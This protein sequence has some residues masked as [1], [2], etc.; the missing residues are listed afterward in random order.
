ME[1]SSVSLTP[2]VVKER[3]IPYWKQIVAGGLF[4]GFSPV[5]SGTVASAVACGFY[6][7]PGLSNPL[8][9]LSMAAVAFFAGIPLVDDVEERLGEDPAFFTL[10]EFAGQ[11]FVLASPIFPS[12]FIGAHRVSDVPYLRHRKDL[13]RELARQQGWSDGRDGGRHC[14]RTLRVD[15]RPRNLVRA[16]AGWHRLRIPFRVRL[17]VAAR[18][19]PSP[20]RCSLPCITLSAVLHHID[21]TEE[22]E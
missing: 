17:R 5:A 16:L 22:H 12:I 6:F 15:L 20:L 11:W 3:G 1:K 10:D 9:L 21:E 19:S 8:I 14:C 13:A 18:E 4:T 7:V 2:R